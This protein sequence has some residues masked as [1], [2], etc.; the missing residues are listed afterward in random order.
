MK[1]NERVAS[2]L[3]YHGGKTYLAPKIVRLMPPHVHFVEAYAGGLSVMF[4]KDPNDVSEVANDLD[5]RVATFWRVLR[6]PDLFKKFRRQC[7][8]TEFGRQAF[9]AAY[10]HQYGDDPLADAWAFFVLCRQSMAGR[11]QDFAPLSR[12]RT[13]RGMNEQASAWLSAVTGLEAVH[14]RPRRVVVEQMDALEL[15]QRADDAETL[16]YLD[17]PYLPQ[18][19]SPGQVYT[20]DMTKRDHRDLLAVIR[21][22]RGKVM[23]SGYPSAMYGKRLADWNMHTFDSPNHA[24]GGAKKR[25]MTEAVWCNF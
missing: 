22:C 3:K 20:H 2:P 10:N 7:E 12:R 15:I 5:G 1:T 6:E 25:R 16:Y 21:Q 11:Q 8:A 17:P 9:R 24:A 18:V 13:R 4:N 23:L 19:R 14:P